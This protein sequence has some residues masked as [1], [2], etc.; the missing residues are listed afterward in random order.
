M[1]YGPWVFPNWKP[2][3]R[4]QVALAIPTGITDP[5]ILLVSCLQQC[6]FASVVLDA[7]GVFVWGNDS[8]PETLKRSLPE[9]G[10][11]SSE[12]DRLMQ[13]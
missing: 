13:L 11:G 10:T 4:L 8:G 12:F 9:F 1:T 2:G 6:Y 3:R 5:N 7:V